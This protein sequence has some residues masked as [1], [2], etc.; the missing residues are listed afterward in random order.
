MVH[1]FGRILASHTNNRAGTPSWKGSTR[2]AAIVRTRVLNQLSWASEEEGSRNERRTALCEL[3]GLLTQLE[4]I[5]MRGTEVPGR[6]RVA[7]QR[8]GIGLRSQEG[9]AEL[10]EAIFVEQER[11]MLRPEQAKPP[12]TGHARDLDEL[13]RRIAS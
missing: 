6:I 2:M 10:I 9:P 5:N 11:Y 3:D 12:V 1:P 8:H 4:E 13:R 7:L